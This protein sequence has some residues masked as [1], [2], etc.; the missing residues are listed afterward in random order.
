MAPPITLGTLQGTI[1]NGPIISGTRV[2]WDDVAGTSL[3]QPD[4]NGRR[5]P[6]VMAD[7]ARLAGVS[8]Q[9]VSRVINGHDSV[10]A[11]TR[12]RVLGAIRELEYVPSAVARSLSSQRT[13]TLGMVTT[14]E[15]VETEAQLALLKSVGCTEAQ[16]YLFSPAKPES[17][18]PGLLARLREGV[19][20]AA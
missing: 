20:S 3:P 4:D 7:V 2:V 19:R 1:G 10:T 18:V 9:T 15:G 6:A 17:D 5:R 12:D 13:H 11:E 16:G 8:H 14:A